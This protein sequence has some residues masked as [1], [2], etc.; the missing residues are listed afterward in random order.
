M[1]WNKFKAVVKKYPWLIEQVDVCQ[2]LV[3]PQ[4]A[5]YDTS[6]LGPLREFVRHVL[7]YVAFRPFEALDLELKRG[8][9]QVQTSVEPA[10]CCEEHLGGN[11]MAWYDEEWATI[12]NRRIVRF[13]DQQKITETISWHQDDDT[14]LLDTIKGI[15]Q[16]HE[17]RGT[18]EYS[19]DFI[20]QK[21]TEGVL[22]TCGADRILKSISI[23]V[24][25]VP[26]WFRWSVKESQSLRVLTEHEREVR[27]AY[28]ASDP[29]PP[30]IPGA[31]S[32]AG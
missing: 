26:V 19:I 18:T 7:D 30:I 20:L 22:G 1:K 29:L 10:F 25:P 14:S 8:W 24:Y 2:L 21:V 12:V 27:R 9:Y 5:S 6:R 4:T 3:N 17:R 16:F 32:T 31:I 23:N 13:R 28:A 15:E 11:P